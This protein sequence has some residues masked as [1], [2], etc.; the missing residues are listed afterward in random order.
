MEEGTGSPHLRLGTTHVPLFRASRGFA[1]TH[2]VPYTCSSSDGRGFC[3]K[4]NLTVD[5]N[6]KD[7][8]SLQQGVF[9]RSCSCSS[10]PRSPKTRNP[11]PWS[12]LIQTFTVWCLVGNGGMDPYNPQ[13]KKLHDPFPHSLLRTRQFTR[14]L[15]RITSGNEDIIHL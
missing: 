2:T 10:S 3:P 6:L 15:L 13:Q 14:W 7:Q 5:L 1:I 11:K 4:K 12:N 8:T 9:G